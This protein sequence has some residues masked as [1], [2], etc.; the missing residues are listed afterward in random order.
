MELAADVCIVGA[1][2]AGITL[3]RALRGSGLDVLVL[4]GGGLEEDARLQSL[5]EGTM[6]GLDSWRLDRQRV[7]IFGGTTHHW[8]GWCTPLLPEDFEARAHIPESGWPIAYDDLAPYYV[9]AAELVQIDAGDWDGGALAG[10][11]GLPVLP[12]PLGHLDTRLYK[13]S[14]PTRFGVR[15]RSDLENADDVD[16]VYRA[17]LTHIALAPGGGSVDRLEVRVLDGP[18]FTVTA[19]RFVLALGGI[20]NAR[21]LLASSDRNPD[22]VS[23]GAGLVGRYF[24]EHPHLYEIPGWVAPAG[25]DVRFYEHH[26]SSTLGTDVRGGVGLT[27]ETRST[28]GL[29]DMVAGGV[30]PS[31]LDDPLD[32]VAPSMVR[33]L[34]RN[35]DDAG[36]RRFSLRAEQRPVAD[37]RVRLGSSVDA[38]GIPRVELDWRVHPDD[39]AAYRRFADLVAAELG[40]AGVGR[41]WLP[42]DDGNRAEWHISGG[43]HHMGTTRMGA[44]AA[45]GVV[46]ADCRSFEV[47][48]LYL[49]GSSVFRTG[50][51]ANPTLTLVAL[52]LR[53][54]D[55]ILEQGS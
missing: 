28:E 53:L 21:M 6:V 20:E 40:A 27:R 48:N 9:D 2:A 8:S 37:S 51:S 39:L 25:V 11:E 3:A 13:F 44:S 23:N 50:G 32:G 18:A 54:A 49:A 19:G 34:L 5:Y 22:G 46:D 31:S 47:D 10:Q 1:G 30:P 45:D 12:S 14:P 7:R 38:L 55:H 36:F 43:G 24:M 4:E 42:V 35:A 33:P 52:A 16:V 26:F 29:P 41:L 17:N 15:Y